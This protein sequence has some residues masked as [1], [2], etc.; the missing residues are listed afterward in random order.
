MVLGS[1]Q[2]LTEMSS[3]NISW[4]VKAICVLGWH[5]YQI[6]VRTVLKSGSLKIQAPSGHVQN[7]NGTALHMTCYLHRG[8]RRCHV[9]GGYAGPRGLI[10]LTT[11]AVHCGQ[12]RLMSTYQKPFVIREICHCEHV[13]WREWLRLVRE[14]YRSYDELEVPLLERETDRVSLWDFFLWPQYSYVID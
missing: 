8:R 12:F 7:C 4:G 13:M 14:E 5:P 2:P 1:T 3:R 10:L 11:L 9:N 6:H